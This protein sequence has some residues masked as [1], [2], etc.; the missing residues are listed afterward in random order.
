MLHP[1]L[2]SCLLPLLAASSLLPVSHAATWSNTMISYRYG[3]KFSEP[4]NTQDIAKHIIGFTHASGYAYGTN[5]FNVDLLLS[6]KN[7]PAGGKPGFQGAQEAYVVYRNL[8]D[9]GKLTGNNYRLGPIKMFGW[10]TG[11]D[12]NTKNN[13][14]ASKKRML[15]T[16]PTVGLDVPRGF[17]NVS[18]LALFESNSPSFIP[19]RYR[20]DTHPAVNVAWSIPSADKQWSFNGYALWITEKGIDERGKPTADETHIDANVMYDLGKTL[21]TKPGKI[22][23]GVQYEYWR[24][25][26]GSSQATNGA[27][28]GATAS[29]PM[30]RAEYQF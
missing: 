12:L 7:D 3:E 26:F 27:G 19:E 20:Y 2:F 5:F 13:F 15:V 4:F 22:R 24:N 6:D 16:G 21:Q 23:V 11:F 17:V 28:P 30:I 10:T 8:L 14:Y 1:R 25:K 9:I 18:V 29:T